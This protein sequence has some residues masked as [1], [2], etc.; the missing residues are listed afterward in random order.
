[1]YDVHE[2]F[3]IAIKHILVTT[4]LSSASNSA[5]EYAAWLATSEKAKVT[6]FYSVDNLPSVAYHTVDLTFDKF[7]EEV[8]KHEKKKLQEF[9]ERFRTLFPKPITVVITEGNAPQAIVQYA[10]E[11]AIDIIIMNT[12]GRTG[13]QHVL[14]GSVAERVVRT[15]GCPVLTIKP[16]PAEERPAKKERRI[17]A[18]KK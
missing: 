14:L 15:A 7:R 16:A 2:V 10:A 6:L 11:H 4:D 18:A 1:M 17:S 9:A 3:M 12:H 8:I 13:L 5:M